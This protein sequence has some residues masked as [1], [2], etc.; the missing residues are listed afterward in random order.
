MSTIIGFFKDA[1]SELKKIIWPTR[2]DTIR[3]TI[4]VIVFSVIFA[5]I[6]GAWDIA[7]L[8]GIEVFIR[9]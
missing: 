5:L 9:K 1:R 2:K 8:K 4:A 6:L 7:L 3:Y